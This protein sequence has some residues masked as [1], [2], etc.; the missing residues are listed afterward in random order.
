MNIY[1]SQTI[2]IRF[3]KIGGMS[4]SS[5]FQVGTAGAIH[6]SSQLANTG[7]FT[8]PAPEAGGSQV[9]Q[10]GS[11]SEQIFVPLHPPSA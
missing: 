1:I 6:A 5:M 7:G 10:E 4:N 3:I 2:Q 11:P 9:I 8:G